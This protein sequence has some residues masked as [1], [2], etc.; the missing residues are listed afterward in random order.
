MKPIYEYI[1]KKDTKIKK[2][3]EF[4]KYQIEEDI[5][6]FLERQNFK[7][8]DV[9]EFYDT[10]NMYYRISHRLK[11]IEEKS[12]NRQA[13]Y[14]KENSDSEF[15]EIWFFNGGKIS[16]DNPVF[17]VNVF[18]NNQRIHKG[19]YSSHVYYNINCTNENMRNFSY[20][21]FNDFRKLLNEYNI[22]SYKE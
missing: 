18:P 19:Y 14:L 13:Y 12:K 7:K 10:L 4:P 21:Q 15:N 22:S 5:I 20:D 2:L 16:K 8:I 17:S 9:I 6:D 1:L 11:E 3:E